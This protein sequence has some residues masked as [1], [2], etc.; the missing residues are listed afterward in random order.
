MMR[1]GLTTI[2][3]RTLTYR[4]NVRGY[5]PDLVRTK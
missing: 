5:H 4:K 2:W 1:N 3:K